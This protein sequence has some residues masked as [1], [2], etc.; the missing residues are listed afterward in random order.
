MGISRRRT[1]ALLGGGMVVSAGAGVAVFAATRTPQR[2]LAPWEMTAEYDDP[3]LRALSYA[4]LAPNPH[5]LQPWMA[6][7]VGEDAVAL[8]R[9]PSRGL[10]ET[11]PLGRQITIGFGCFLEQMAVAASLDG[12]AVETDL[13]PEGPDGPVAIARFVAGAAPDPL[14]AHMLARR[15]CKEPFATGRPVAAEGLAALAAVQNPGAPIAGSVEPDRVAAL[16]DLIWRAWEIEAQTPRTW[17]ESVDLLRVG[18]PEIEATPDGIDLQSPFLEALRRLGM[19]DRAALLDTEGPG[20]TSTLEAYR[21]TFEATPAFVWV[22]SAGNSR[23]DQ[24]AAGRSWLR[25][26]LATTAAGLALHPVSQ[27]LQEYPEMAGPYAEAHEMLGAPGETVQ[28]LGRLGY[29]PEVPPAPRWPLE[30]K[31]VDARNV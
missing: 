1:L 19:L 4:I 26:N 13:F 22:T 20:F 28:M 9:D 3:R 5:N 12:L 27:A 16:R 7:L 18:R 10:P 29:G 25:L 6:E 23:A 31:L 11:D 14:A 17:A 8:H 15:S 30:A 24:V 21:A 2:A